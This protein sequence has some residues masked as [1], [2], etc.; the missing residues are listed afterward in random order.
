MTWLVGD[1]VGTSPR[2]TAVIG[3]VRI[4]KG[5]A[6]GR[7]GSNTLLSK[8]R[9]GTSAKLSCRSIPNYISM[10]ADCLP[11]TQS[12]IELFVNCCKRLA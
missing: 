12:R 3:V 8:F 6:C 5:V 4:L 11:L 7:I 1:G 2:P 9:R 10:H